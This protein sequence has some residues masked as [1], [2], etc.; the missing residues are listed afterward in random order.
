M[1]FQRSKTLRCGK[2]SLPSLRPYIPSLHNNDFYSP[3]PMAAL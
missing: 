3:R 1:E 2:D